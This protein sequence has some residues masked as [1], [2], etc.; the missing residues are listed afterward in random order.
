MKSIPLTQNKVALIDDEDWS[1]VAD[2]QW[3]AARRHKTFYAVAYVGLVDGKPGQK[4]FMHRLLTNAPKGKE[5]HHIDGNGLNN[6]RTN[7]EVLSR[8]DHQAT[9]GPRKNNSVGYRGVLYRAPYRGRGAFFIAC[10]RRDRKPIFTKFF[11]TSEDAAR[12]YDAKIRELF[13]PLAYQNFPAE[14][15]KQRDRGAQNGDEP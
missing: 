12:A 4:V 11:R 6:V 7:L 2:L 1:L 10:I 13:G 5:V 9:Y 3:Y 14:A 15:A 8:R